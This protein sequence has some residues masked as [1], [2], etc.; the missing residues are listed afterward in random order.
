MPNEVSINQQNN[1]LIPQNPTYNVNIVNT[2]QEQIKVI[3]ESEAST[4]VIIVEDEISVS[5]VIRTDIFFVDSGQ[6]IVTVKK[7]PEKEIITINSPGPQGPQGPAG[8]SGDN[9]GYTTTSSFNEFTSSFY[10]TS[11]SISNRLTSLEYFS[12]SYIPFNGTGSLF[13]TASWS[14]NAITASYLS[15]FIESASFATYA[16]TASYIDPATLANLQISQLNSGSVSAIVNPNGDSIFLIKSGSE[17]MLNIASTGDVNFYT[18][19]FVIRNFTTKQPVLTISQ[20]SV[21]FATQSM[22]PTGFTFAGS[23]WFTSSS[24]YIGLD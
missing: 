12:S 22:D 10:V 13:G 2:G 24:M 20:S 14:V 18:N 23:I 11:G 7:D 3:N 8:P 16:A 9:S 4:N 6:S 5:E 19:L 17:N 21:I 1:T 15:G